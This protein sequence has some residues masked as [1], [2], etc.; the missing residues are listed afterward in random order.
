VIASLK[1][2][3]TRCSFHMMVEE[4]MSC[5]RI[6]NIIL[7]I[8]LSLTFL[9]TQPVSA[10][11][12]IFKQEPPNRENNLPVTVRLEY[13]HSGGS[14]EYCIDMSNDND[15]DTSWT[16]ADGIF[17]VYDLNPNTTYYWQIR[18]TDGATYADNGAWWSFTTTNSA[19]N[20]PD[21]RIT[22]AKYTPSSLQT[23][24]SHFEVKVANSGTA[25]AQSFGLSIYIDKKPVYDCNDYVAHDYG[26]KYKGWLNPIN[27]G[28]SQIRDFNDQIDQG[29]SAGNHQIY[30]RVDGD[31]YINESNETNNIFGPVNITI[32]TPST[33][34]LPPIILVHGFQGLSTTGGYHCSN[35]GDGSN[36]IQKYDGTDPNLSTLNSADGS[37]DLADWFVQDGYEVWI[38][39]LETSPYATLT[40]ENNASCLRDQINYVYSKNPQPITIVAHSMGGLV[41]RA[42]L[43]ILPNSVDVKALYTL[44][45]PHAGIPL[46][47]FH[48]LLSESGGCKIQQG[49][50]QMDITFMSLYFNRLNPNLKDVKYYFIGGDGGSG[51][52]DSLLKPSEGPNDG[53]VGRASAVGLRYPY[54]TFVPSDWVSASPPAQYWTNETHP[55]ESDPLKSYY[56]APVGHT[57]SDAF[58]CMKTLM[59]G[60]NPG[61]QYCQGASSQPIVANSVQA[62]AGSSTGLT[63]TETKSGYLGAGQLLTIPLTMDTASSLS[64]YLTW[65]G[66]NAP[67]FTLTT[68]DSQ[69][70]D[71]VYAASHPGQVSYET[72]Q[73]SPETP[74]YAVY[75][76]VSG[77]A[78]VWQLNITATDAINYQAFGMMDSSRTL[79]A[80]TDKDT[81]QIGDAA[82]ITATLENGGVG[83][84]GATVTANLT[85]QDSTVDTVNLTDP[86][87]DGSYTASYPIPGIPGQLSIEI[88]ATGNDSGTAYTRQ[89]NILVSI[90]PNDLH[91]TGN[92]AALPNDDNEDLLYEYLDFDVEVNADLVGEYAISAELYAG[93]QLITQAADFYPLSAGIQTVTL[94]FDGSAIREMGLNGPYTI[95]NLYATP[96]DIG[97]TAQ[98]ATNVRT[99]TAYSYTQFGSRTVNNNYSI[100]L[101]LIMH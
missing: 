21:L 62:Q 58:E 3:A 52:M 65:S 81:Y 94:R 74:P 5:K 88:I 47:I 51:F 95:S 44:G 49:M 100:Y 24:A 22:Q 34:N 7:V 13:G 56:V 80:Q 82:T 30:I 72:G 98:S 18:T 64:I 41:S 69:I 14:Y 27:P 32:G 97:I 53:L 99:T 71:P 90:A 76:F 25:T 28:Q 84:P 39:H 67:S 40:L 54:M 93:N 86:E 1:R 63:F 78:G 9:N 8:A 6:L 19:W 85:F 26:W 91:L 50:C 36:D 35:D 96:L 46:D 73:G 48:N 17:F 12:F 87:N 10:T 16:P 70:I 77:Q 2:Q 33:Q 43:K 20:K 45:S 61:S 23:G 15:C 4:N 59:S 42:A 37:P 66:G 92:Y 29:L 89:E 101:P 31:C 57:H 75:S 83:M 60:G 79:V 55:A 38:A 68:P 11:E